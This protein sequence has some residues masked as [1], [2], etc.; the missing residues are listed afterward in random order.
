MQ[1]FDEVA[2]KNREMRKIVGAKIDYGNEME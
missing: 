2:S 1:Q